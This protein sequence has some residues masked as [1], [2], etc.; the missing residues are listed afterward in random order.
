MNSL[1]ATNNREESDTPSWLKDESSSSHASF[2]VGIIFIAFTIAVAIVGEWLISQIP[3]DFALNFAGNTVKLRADISIFFVWDLAAILSMLFYF[4]VYWY[5]AFSNTGPMSRGGGDVSVVGSAVGFMIFALLCIFASFLAGLA[6]AFSVPYS[7]ETQLL[8]ITLAS[9]LILLADN[10][11]GKRHSSKRTRLEFRLFVE[12]VDWP[13]FICFLVLTGFYV[14]YV[15]TENIQQFSAFMSGA[16]A[17]QII[18]FN[19][20][21]AFLDRFTNVISRGKMAVLLTHDEKEMDVAF[22][23]DYA[24][25]KRR[26]SSYWK[27]VS[28]T[29]PENEDTRNAAAPQGPDAVSKLG[30]VPN[31]GTNDDEK[32]HVG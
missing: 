3:K 25:F 23:A 13:M 12:F 17:F 10:S 32:N 29:T 20:A 9:L 2:I 15:S 26:W 22:A 16:I 6:F 11:V 7:M 21:F 27:Y 31:T 28:G 5:R 14:L 8:L 4:G 18:A 24:E 30:A 1:L 19:V